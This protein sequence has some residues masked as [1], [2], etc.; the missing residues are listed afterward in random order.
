M[1][2]IKLNVTGSGKDTDVFFNM[3]KVVYFIAHNGKTRLRVKDG[4]Y[5]SFNVKETPEEI[6]MLLK[7]ATKCTC[8]CCSS[9]DSCC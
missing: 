4:T 1:K 3:S 9:S 2:F 7:D 6:I 5:E 8:S